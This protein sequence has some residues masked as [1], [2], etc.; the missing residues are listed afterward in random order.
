MSGP[1]EVA[2]VPA[3][4]GADQ[5]QGDGDPDHGAGHAAKGVL[6][7]F[8]KQGHPVERGGD[9][10]QNAIHKMAD[11]LERKYFRPKHGFGRSR[12]ATPSGP[13]KARWPAATEPPQPASAFA[14]AAK[15]SPCPIRLGMVQQPRC[16]FRSTSMALCCT[17]AGRRRA[18]QRQS[19]GKQPV[20]NSCVG[21]ETS[22]SM[23]FRSGARGGRGWQ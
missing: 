10:A 23:R 1:S 11:W 14:A 4:H 20:P 3:H 9:K 2:F 22:R 15:T 16:L 5:C 18:G 21:I 13:G 6:F 7:A 17:A 8:G 19:A 12:C